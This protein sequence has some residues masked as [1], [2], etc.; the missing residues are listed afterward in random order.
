MCL[1]TGSKNT[2]KAVSREKLVKVDWWFV[3]P[4][5]VD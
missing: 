5:I 2:R 1:G 4:D 3:L